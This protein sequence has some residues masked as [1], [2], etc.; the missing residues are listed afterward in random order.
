MASVA[1]SENDLC[2]VRWGI[3][4]YSLTQSLVKYMKVALNV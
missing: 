2:H 3:K 4:L 1:A